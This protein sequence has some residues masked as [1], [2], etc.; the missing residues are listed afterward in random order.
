MYN[1]ISKEFR[2]GRWV[3]AVQ[4][5]FQTS[6][7]R[8]ETQLEAAQARAAAEGKTLKEIKLKKAMLPILTKERQHHLRISRRSDPAFL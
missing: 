1:G 8:F 3:W 7:R 5:K 2:G 6:Q 4:A